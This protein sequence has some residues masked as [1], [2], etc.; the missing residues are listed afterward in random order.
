MMGYGINCYLHVS[1]F[2]NNIPSQIWSVIALRQKLYENS[3]K[4]KYDLTVR[5]ISQKIV[6]G[7]LKDEIMPCTARNNKNA[8]NFII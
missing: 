3:V 6:L 2:V 5:G 4:N 1:F 7:Q 8:I